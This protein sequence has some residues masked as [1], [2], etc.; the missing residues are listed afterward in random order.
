MIHDELSVD[1]VGGDAVMVIVLFILF[2]LEVI[3]MFGSCGVCWGGGL[4]LQ[5]LL[6]TVG[7]IRIRG[8]S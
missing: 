3:R 1:D 4:C 8:C 6:G 5:V 7:L 2:V